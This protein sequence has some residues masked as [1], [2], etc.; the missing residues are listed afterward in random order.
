MQRKCH[1]FVALVWSPP[2]SVGI[3][4]YP[5]ETVYSYLL[6]LETGLVMMIKIRLLS[7]S[8]PNQKYL[9]GGLK[10]LNAKER[11][12]NASFLIGKEMQVTGRT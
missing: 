8:F 12:F 9:S 10:F 7:K 6:L 3:S 4:A 2:T 5:S 1:I 11:P